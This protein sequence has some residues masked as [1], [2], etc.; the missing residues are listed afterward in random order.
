MLLFYIGMYMAM[1]GLSY[2]TSLK[3]M[4]EQSPFHHKHMKMGGTV[5]WSRIKRANSMVA[6]ACEDTKPMPRP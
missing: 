2:T 6:P 1:A 4:I 5:H 3:E